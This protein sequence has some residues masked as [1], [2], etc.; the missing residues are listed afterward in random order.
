ML[1]T[2]AVLAYVYINHI[3]RGS[4][5]MLDDNLILECVCMCSGR[6]SLYLI[7]I[8]IYCMYVCTYCMNPSSEFPSAA[9]RDKSQHQTIQIAAAAAAFHAAAGAADAGCHPGQVPA[10]L[11]SAAP[12][13]LG[14]LRL[15]WSGSGWASFTT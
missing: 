3:Y 14:V 10:H 11:P 5:E 1:C 15:E 7:Y 8:Y 13:F 9:K 12:Q 2:H 6:C 4:M